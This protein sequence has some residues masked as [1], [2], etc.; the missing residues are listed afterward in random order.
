MKRE[1]YRQRKRVIAIDIKLM[2]RRYRF[3][4]K[5]VLTKGLVKKCH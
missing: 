4:K 3:E 2:A 1:T 5:L